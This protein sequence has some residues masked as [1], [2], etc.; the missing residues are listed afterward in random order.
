MRLSHQLA[1]S[2][3]K[4][5][6][7]LKGHLLTV[8]MKLESDLTGMQEQA[9]CFLVSTDSAIQGEV[10]I[11]SISNYGEAITGGL[12]TQLMR[13]ARG[14]LK[15]KE[16]KAFPSDA[17]TLEVHLGDGLSAP[18][19]AFNAQFAVLPCDLE[20]VFPGLVPA[21][22]IFLSEGMVSFADPP[23]GENCPHLFCQLAVAGEEYDSRSGRV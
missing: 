23:F 10:A 14:G 2:S 16:R 17:L 12:Y 4:G 3:R 19:T 11:G 6:F 7:R 15:A 13:D 8:P 1:E 20:L 5:R 18:R 21:R 9:P 22:S